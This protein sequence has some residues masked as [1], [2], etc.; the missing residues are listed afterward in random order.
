M[1]RADKRIAELKRLRTAATARSARPRG[2]S[3]G[4]SPLHRRARSCQLDHRPAPR[5]ARLELDSC[6]LRPAEPGRRPGR[7]SP[8]A[9]RRD[10]RKLKRELRQPRARA[11]RGSMTARTTRDARSASGCAPLGRSAPGHRGRRATTGARRVDPRLPHPGHGPP[12][13]AEGGAAVDV[14]PGETGF[15]RPA[16]G[17]VHAGLRLHRLPARAASRGCRHFHDGIDIA[18]RSGSRIRAAAPGRRRLLR[19]GTRGTASGAPTSSSSDIAAGSRPSTGTC[20]RSARSASARPCVAGKVIGLMGSTGNSTGP[21]LHWEV[22]R[23]SDRPR[24]AP[25]PLSPRHSDPARLAV[26]SASHAEDGPTM[27]ALIPILVAA[28]AVPSRRRRRSPRRT[29]MNRDTSCPRPP[30]RRSS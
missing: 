9:P 20:V 21:H 10:V 14:R 28:L 4:A 3:R 24:P 2:A 26:S 18:G 1:R 8:A 16:R 29:T 17:S 7:A 27:R 23:G 30:A 13:A 19:A 12:R 25:L 11:D 15:R 5:L 22:R 6:D